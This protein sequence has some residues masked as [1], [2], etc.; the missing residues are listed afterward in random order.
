M[1]QHNNGGGGGVIVVHVYIYQHL[2]LALL[3]SADEHT[4]GMILAGHQTFIQLCGKLSLT[5]PR[6]AF[7]TSLCKASLPP[8]CVLIRVVFMLVIV[9][10]LH[11]Q[12]YL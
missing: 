4:T 7:L 5:T 10:V 8:R 11:F 9:L 12:V 6:D 2:H 1:I 3:C